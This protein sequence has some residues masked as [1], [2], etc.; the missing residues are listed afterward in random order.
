MLK[1]KLEEILRGPPAAA[2]H[3][4]VGV[5]AGATGG[6]FTV[7]AGNP[8]VTSGP[9]AVP[10][11][12]SLAE[13]LGPPPR[14]PIMAFEGSAKR[15][16]A[17]FRQCGRPEAQLAWADRLAGLDV[18]EEDGWVYIG[19]AAQLRE[20]RDRWGSLGLARQISASA[21]QMTTGPDAPRP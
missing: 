21:V 11:F 2:V 17:W 3:E 16:A 19:T 7:T 13:R 15:F 12:A 6:T 8:P 5:S 14:G 4:A 18:V 9:F 1:A 10:G 20:A